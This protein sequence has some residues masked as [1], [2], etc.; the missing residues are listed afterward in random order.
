MGS[1]AKRQCGRALC[2]VP[3]HAVQVG[4]LAVQRQG[5]VRVRGEVAA[6]GGQWVVELLDLRP[7]ALKQLGRLYVLPFPVHGRRRRAARRAAAA[8]QARRV[9]RRV[10]GVANPGPGLQQ[11]RGLEA[12]GARLLPDAV[13]KEVAVDLLVGLYPIV[14]LQYR[15][16]TL[17]QVS[18]HIR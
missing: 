7:H 2:G 13:L 4:Q 10:G 15:S 3:D 5:A 14:T 16:I 17:Y 11:L 1:G 18:Y 6:P 12:R 8:A 9:C